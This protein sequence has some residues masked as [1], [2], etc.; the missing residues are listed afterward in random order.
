MSMGSRNNFWDE[1]SAGLAQL[2]QPNSE[3]KYRLYYNLETM[4]GEIISMD[5]LE[6]P[7]VDFPA[8]NIGIPPMDWLVKK[9]KTIVHE[10]TTLPTRR[11]LIKDGTMFYTLKNDYQFAVD[12]DYPAAIG[13][14]YD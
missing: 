6:G 14:S 1:V 3:L 9:D 7:W 10:V 4:R 8:E 12:A 11:K 5:E 2:A 13:W